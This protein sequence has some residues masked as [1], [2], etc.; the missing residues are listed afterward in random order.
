MNGIFCS[1]TSSRYIL[2]VL[3]LNS[4]SF[5]KVLMFAGIM[6]RAVASAAPVPAEVKPIWL[7][8]EVANDRRL[9]FPD[10]YFSADHVLGQ[11]ELDRI[12]KTTG[13]H[14]IVI[15]SS[16]ET[17][18][19]SLVFFEFPGGISSEN[20][21]ICSGD[22]THVVTVESTF[23]GDTIFWSVTVP[24]GIIGIDITA[25]FGFPP[26]TLP[27]WTLTNTTI[28][29]QSVEVSL[30]LG[31][32]PENIEFSIEVLPEI[33]IYLGP[34]SVSDTL[35]FGEEFFALVNTNVHD[36][37]V[38]WTV[39]D[40]SVVSGGSAGSGPFIYS[41]LFNPAEGLQS[42]QY[43]FSTPNALC[44][45]DTLYFDVAVAPYFELLAMDSIQFCPGEA[46]LLE[47]YSIALD[48]IAFS[49]QV[50]GGAI[51]LSDVGD[52]YLT[53]FTADNTSNETV[54]A[55]ILLEAE[56]YGCH[57]VTEVSVTV[58]PQPIL[59]VVGDSVQACSD[60]GLAV[61]FNSTVGNAELQWQFSEH[62]FI[63][64]G[65][66]GSGMGSVWLT[67]TLVNTSSELDSVLVTISTPE[68]VC[69]A[70]P[71][72]WYVEVVPF[73]EL[74]PQ[75]D[76]LGCPG[77][78]I[79]VPDY[80]LPFADM[81]YE[82]FLEG[83][84]LG[85]D[86]EGQ[87]LF[88]GWIASN[89]S[90]TLSQATIHVV[91]ELYACRDTMSFEVAVAPLPAVQWT[92]PDSP[93][94]SGAM[95]D[96]VV[97]TSVDSALVHWWPQFDDVISGPT[98]GIGDSIVHPVFNASVGVDSIVYVLTTSG[99]VCAA[100]TA[101]LT[102]D[103]LP[104]FVLPDLE[105]VT[106]CHGVEVSLAD[107]DLGIEGV[108]YGWSNTNSAW[109]LP[110][111]GQGMLTNWTAVNPSDQPFYGSIDVFASL[112]SC[113]VEFT[114]FDV[115]IH[116]TPLVDFNVGPN[117][118]LDCQ[119]GLAMIEGLS[120][121]GSGTFEWSGPEVIQASD[122]WAEVES[123][124]VYEVTFVDDLSS[125]EATF[126]VE[127]L[128]AT[129]LEITEVL[130]DSLQCN[131]DQNGAIALQLTGD[132]EALF[133]WSPPVSAGASAEDIGA[134]LYAVVVTNASN[135][136]DSTEIE[137]VEMPKLSLE[138]VDFGPAI[139][140][141]SNGFLEVF[142]QGG[143]GVL[144]YNWGGGN[145]L[146]YQGIASGSYPIAITDGLGC[147]L[148]TTLELVCLDE[149]PVQVNQLITPNGD[150][151]NDAWYLG[152]LYPYPNHRVQI[153]N[154]WGSLVFEASPYLNDWKGT[155]EA[156]G[157]NGAPLP[158]A[159]YYY[160]FETGLDQP[161]MFRGFIEIQNEAR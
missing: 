10:A 119:T 50:I 66:S 18:T 127:V 72:L 133:E 126:E 56:L 102:I 22:S 105:D 134:G 84:E 129:A 138:L 51:G 161:K 38:E 6:I 21:T 154:R 63:L 2:N 27:T 65:Q 99:S 91:A 33:E 96:I 112:D 147:A 83:D 116:P 76:I 122:N 12:R 158:S 35:C 34:T 143:D 156:A 54:M 121:L 95:I 20:Q 37:Y 141:M 69:P 46:V 111:S 110:D 78:D 109:G 114:S 57:D 53:G 125:C 41:P 75:L 13:G 3:N 144:D 42:L 97:G 55:Q 150:G 40:S 52:G 88:L 106:G 15:N 85:V 117:G 157:G 30:A 5:A 49:W 101:F 64:N 17:A 135:C 4:F 68:Y 11:L 89:D 59:S 124:G 152:D 115:V 140:G 137:L 45:A 132:V 128:I 149:I 131:G 98:S 145:S 60:I 159:T 130:V 70:S 62:P 32:L 67:D 58:D 146:Y 153:F 148:D 25:G 7:L 160:L 19:S 90:S 80:S 113:P 123:A 151:F 118:G 104:S 23:P 26:F 81:N 77:D 24:N 8:G 16:E 36:V 44:P 9:V 71:L 142:A 79:L 29:S 61:G 108:V 28:S 47:D 92:A 86:Q 139:C 87:G 1:F 94:C 155:W 100:D 48:D 107:Y 93:Y 74:L 136:I 39:D 73:F 31:C 43:M 120:M 103:V 14:R 82:W